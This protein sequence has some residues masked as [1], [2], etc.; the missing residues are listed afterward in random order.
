MF[1]FTI[2]AITAV[3]MEMYRPVENSTS[4]LKWPGGLDNATN[5]SSSSSHVILIQDGPI[6]EAV[7]EKQFLILIPSFIYLLLLVLLGVPGNL[8]VIV[9][10][11]LKMTRTTSRTFIISLAVCDFI[12][13]AFG[14]PVELGLIANYY[15]FDLPLLCKVSRFSNFLMNNISSVVLLGIA[16]DRFRRVCLPLRPNMTVRHAKMICFIGAIISIIFAAP[17]LLLYGTRTFHIPGS[18]NNTIIVLKA[19]YI[20]DASWKTTYPMVFN[21]FLFVSVLIIIFA[22]TVMYALVGRVVCRRQKFSEETVVFR[23]SFHQNLNQE[24]NQNQN[25]DVN[26]DVQERN[27]RNGRSLSMTTRFWR[28]ISEHSPKLL[29]HGQRHG[30][31]HTVHHVVNTNNLP[32]I[33]EPNAIRARTVSDTSVRRHGGKKVRAGRTT[34]IL[35][36]VTLLY[37]LTFVPYLTIVTMRYINPYMV[38]QMSSV[39]LSVFNLMLRSYVTNSAF[40]PLIY[41]F[42]NREFRLKVKRFFMGLFGH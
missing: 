29:R 21:L 41:C 26:T 19:C 10:Y 35:F 18:T 17:A 3:T 27:V 1:S 16:V 38:E 6:L 33:L 39:E 31:R 7:N 36:L 42:L 32:D 14:M 28:S 25:F 37:I 23:T 34:M 4:L 22:L 30:H 8:T 20:N 2:S 9:I 24:A 12:N 40:N 15:R 13:C 11:L 5:T